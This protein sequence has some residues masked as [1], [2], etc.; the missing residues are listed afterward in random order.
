MTGPSDGSTSG[1]AV[2]MAIEHASDPQTLHCMEI[3]GG[4]E[5]VESSVKTPGLDLW[6]YSRPFEGTSRGA[7]S[8]S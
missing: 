8:I 6:V 5:P 1:R 4:I 2:W 7:T 3:W